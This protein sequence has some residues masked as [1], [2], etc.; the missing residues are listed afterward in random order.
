MELSD[1]A[2][3]EICS[4]GRFKE[5]RRGDM[6]VCDWGKGKDAPMSFEFR[7]IASGELCIATHFYSTGHS[8]Y[9][10]TIDVEE[11]KTCPYRR[12]D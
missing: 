8:E 7:H 3:R 2:V 1:K 9:D 11:M 6:I 5:R 4:C 12:L 10:A